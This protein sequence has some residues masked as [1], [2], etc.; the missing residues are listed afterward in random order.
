MHIDAYHFGEIVIDGKSYSKDVICH[1]R[2]V[3]AN[4]FRHEG[5]ELALGDI[6][7]LLDRHCTTLIVGTGASGQ[8]HVSPE[9]VDFCHNAHIDLITFPTA[10]AVRRYNAADPAT[11]VG[12]FHLTC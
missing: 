2:G 3:L 12:A 10:E 4:W 11:T 7:T 5:H 8:L 1:P 6:D 9:V